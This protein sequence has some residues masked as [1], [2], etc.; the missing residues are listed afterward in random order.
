MKDRVQR[1]QDAISAVFAESDNLQRDLQAEGLDFAEAKEAYKISKYTLALLQATVTR[2][3]MIE[4]RF[5]LMVA[6]AFEKRNRLYVIRRE[7]KNIHKALTW[8]EIGGFE[9]NWDGQQ[10]HLLDIARKTRD[11]N[12]A[13]E[14]NTA[15]TN[16]GFVAGRLVYQIWSYQAENNSWTL[17]E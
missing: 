10:F 14:N 12:N 13:H 4:N 1:L 2:A 7:A 8:E 16:R 5:A 17:I 11:R 3:Q 9:F 6:Y 15:R